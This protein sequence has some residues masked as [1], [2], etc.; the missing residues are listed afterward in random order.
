MIPRRILPFLAAPPAMAQAGPRRGILRYA[1]LGLDTADPHRHTGSIAVQ[2]AYVE[3]L[4]SIGPDGGVEPFLAERFSLSGDGLIATFHLRPGVMFHDGSVMD[5]AAVRA[6]IERVRDRIRGGWL[7]GAMRLIT[8]IETPDAG[9]V[10]LRLSQPYAPLL[11]SLSELWIVSPRSPGW[12]GT[13]TRP[14]GTGPFLF[15]QWQPNLRLQ[16]P[17][18]PHYWRPGQP[19]LEAVHFDLRGDVDKG[20][21]LRAGDLHVADVAQDVA[22]QLRADPRFVVQG[23]RDTTWYFLAFNN[24]R[25]R[26][27]F[28]NPLVR[29]ALGHVLDKPGFMRFV[30]GE[31]GVVTN[32][33][34]APGNLYFDQALHEADPYRAP[35]LDQARALL[36]EA[37]VDPGRTAIEMVS[38]QEPYAQAAVQ[39]VRRLGFRVTHTPLDDIGAQRRLGQYD[40][41]IC[42]MASGPRADVFLR[43]VRLM[44]DGPNPVLWGGIQDPE[45]DGMIRAAAAEPALEPR[46]AKYAQAWA[47]VAEK[48]YFLVLGH[49]ANQIAWRREVRGFTTGF[50]WSP[51]R[52][53]GGIAA[54]SLG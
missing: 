15:G 16:A 29:R 43:W 48:H 44:S 30:A 21:A 7:A 33:M 40:W 31:A 10:T 2:Q 8:A 11:T 38:W 36:R 9:T 42:C 37:G 14:A 6:N 35:D 5:A 27:P 22:T 3:A 46:R 19:Q 50:T 39:M 25:P 41:D 20:I 51:H 17:A 52:A 23:L 45:L 47:R 1:T 4:T 54:T 28:D 34:V 32:Q 24:R 12:D 18:N 49:A 13:I 53:D 26:P